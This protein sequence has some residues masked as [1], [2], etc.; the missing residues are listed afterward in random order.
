MTQYI[1]VFKAAKL[2]VLFMQLQRKKGKAIA[3][4]LFNSALNTTLTS[5]YGRWR[6]YIKTTII[7]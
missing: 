6:G 7:M 3:L 1:C 5:Q 2:I 4:L